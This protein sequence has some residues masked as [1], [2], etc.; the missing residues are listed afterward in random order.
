MLLSLFANARCN[1]VKP[2]FFELGNLFANLPDALGL[3]CYETNDGDYVD[4]RD[5]EGD[6]K[7]EA[8]RALGATTLGLGGLIL[9]FYLVA[10]GCIPFSPPVFQL[11]GLLALC[12]CLLQGLVFLVYQSDVCALGCELGTGGMCGISAAVFWFVTGMT[13]L[14]AS[15]ALAGTK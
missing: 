15:K 12:T 6:S 11:F 5:F 3:W 14:V 13:S 4:S 1:L 7:F 9:I 10:A 8:A 2:A